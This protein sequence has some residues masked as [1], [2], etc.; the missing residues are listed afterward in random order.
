MPGVAHLWQL[1]VLPDW[2]GTGVA[3]TLHT[4][5]VDE[6]SAQGYERGRLDTPAAHTRACRF[7]ERRGWQ[8]VELGSDPALGLELAEY[9]LELS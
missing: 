5:A 1:F 3:A 9:G 4:A 7:Y 2:W 8:L 6:M